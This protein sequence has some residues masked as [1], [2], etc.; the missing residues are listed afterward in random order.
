MTYDERACKVGSVERDA[1]Y[2]VTAPSCMEKGAYPGFHA[3]LWTLATP[4]CCAYFAGV[5]QFPQEKV[6]AFSI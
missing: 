1:R 5:A 3:L 4:G 2:A 6:L